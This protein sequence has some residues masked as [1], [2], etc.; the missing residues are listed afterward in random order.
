MAKHNQPDKLSQDASAALA[1]GMTYGKYMAMKEPMKVTPSDQHPE[2]TVCVVSVCELCGQQFTQ[3]D[4][5][6]RKF[7]CTEHCRIAYD[8][9]RKNRNRGIQGC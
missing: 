3:Y 5:R 6:H 2:K 9:T 4:R 7:C 8:R 1:A